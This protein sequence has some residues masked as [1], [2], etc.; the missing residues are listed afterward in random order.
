MGENSI[1]IPSIDKALNTSIQRSLDH[2]LSLSDMAEAQREQQ[3]RQVFE[4]NLRF[5]YN[6]WSRDLLSANTGGDPIYQSGASYGVGGNY[7]NPP[8]KGFGITFGLKIELGYKIRFN[9]NVGVGYGFQGKNASGAATLNINAYN[10]GLGTRA[11]E[12]NIVYDVTAAAYLVGGFG[13]GKPMPNYLLNYNSP[14]PF[15]DNHKW[16]LMYGQALTWNSELNHGKFSFE[17]IQRQGIVG[18]RFGNVAKFSSNNDTETAPFFGG[19]TDK[20]WTGGAILYTPLFEIGYQNFTGEG[21]T[22]DG[23]VAPVAGKEYAGTFY[24]Q[25]DYNRSLNKAS[26]YF[27]FKTGLN[28]NYTLDLYSTGWFQNWIHEHMNNPKFIYPNFQNPN[29]SI[30]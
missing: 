6:N 25:D 19:N 17:D 9:A 1:T 16:S 27:R 22:S 20:G 23:K 18:L 10:F 13:T 4:N 30:K 29:W 11:N 12:N 2:A 5:E 28:S 26:T 7:P 15:P 8:G 3:I 21:R 24:Q 14:S